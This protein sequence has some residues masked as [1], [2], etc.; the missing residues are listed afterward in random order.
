MGNFITEDFPIAEI[1]KN[2]FS[3]L[4]PILCHRNVLTE[5]VVACTQNTVS[6]AIK[7]FRNHPGIISINKNMER[8]RCG[9]FAFEFVSLQ[10]TINEVTEL[11][12]KKSFSDSRLK[13]LISYFVYNNFNNTL[14]SSQYP[15]SLKYAGVTPVFKKDDKSD[16]SNY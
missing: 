1:F 2:Y 12:I 16:K 3:N 7:K 4:S 5:L 11:S 6:A 15:N 14:S 10:E 9:S 8:I 13:D